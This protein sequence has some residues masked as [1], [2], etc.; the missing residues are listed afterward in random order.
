MRIRKLMRGMAAF[1]L[2]APLAAAAQDNCPNRGDLDAMFCDANRDMVADTPADASR[3]RN[4][5]T[6]VFSYTPIEDPAVYE[7]LLQPFT[8][9]LSKCTGKRVAFFQVQSNAAQI[10]A[11]RSG[12]LHVAAF[13]TGAAPFAVNIAGAVPF[14]VRGAADGPQGYHLVVVV[15]K[16]S[17]IK[18]LADLKGRKVAH[19]SPS[20]NSGHLAPLALFPKQGVVPDK[21]YKIIF[22]G[23]HDQS[24]LGVKTGDY[25]AAAVTSDVFRRM[26]QRGQLKAED[27]RVIYES[28]RFPNAA[29]AHSHDLAPALRDKVVSCFMNFRFTEEM[30]H[31]FEGS[32]RFIPATYKADWAL[33]RDV[34]EAGGQSFNRAAYEQET[35]KS[36]RK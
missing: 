8:D 1:A 4:P 10:E 36:A 18:Q 25:D 16:D 28:A 26:T 6:L 11:M 34:A 21:D 35:A 15:R 30:K 12:R 32:D 14:A 29:F 23:K 5:N 17:N 27:Y 3:H 19:T 33:V 22:S 20:S 31:N 2:L 9:H 13:S 24:L 7:K